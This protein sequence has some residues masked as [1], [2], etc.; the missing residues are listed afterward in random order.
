MENFLHELECHPQKTLKVGDGF[1][2]REKDFVGGC[3][4]IGRRLPQTL[5]VSSS[6]AVSWGNVWKT[7]FHLPCRRL[8]RPSEM[9][10]SSVASSLTNTRAKELFSRM[11][12]LQ[13]DGQ[14]GAEA[15]RVL[16]AEGLER[17]EEKLEQSIQS[18][19]DRTGSLVLQ[20]DSSPS[21]QG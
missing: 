16:F 7:L 3:T 12:I 6:T 9:Q 17:V 4:F 21:P 18:L 14:D 19:Q 8:R 13:R 5:F 10:F 20:G 11:K 1:G 2:T 15:C